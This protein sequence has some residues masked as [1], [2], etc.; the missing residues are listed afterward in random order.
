MIQ[1]RLWTNIKICS[2]WFNEILLKTLS[3]NLAFIAFFETCMIKSFTLRILFGSHLDLEYFFNNNEQCFYMSRC[4]WKYEGIMH[5]LDNYF[6]W[7]K[8]C[9]M[10][11]SSFQNQSGFGWELKGEKELEQKHTH[12]WDV[13][14]FTCCVCEKCFVGEYPL[15]EITRTN[16]NLNLYFKPI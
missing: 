10:F 13:Y 9:C 7:S 6:R 15:R 5:T 2:C 4:K 1:K 14:F 16:A 8:F 11:F 3:L 12:T